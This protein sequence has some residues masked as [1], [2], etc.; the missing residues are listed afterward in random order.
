MLDLVQIFDNRLDIVKGAYASFA[1]LLVECARY[2]ID[3]T[4]LK[5]NL[6]SCNINPQRMSFIINLIEKYKPDVRLQLSSLNESLLRL[7][8]VHWRLD[9]CVKVKVTFN[10]IS[11]YPSPSLHFRLLTFKSYI[12]TFERR[13]DDFTVKSF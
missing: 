9:Y 8:D 11:Y 4:A 6:E 12:K 10:C 5:T 2:G 3:K 7:V 13:H 1:I